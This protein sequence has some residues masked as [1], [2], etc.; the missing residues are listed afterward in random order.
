[1]RTRLTAILTIF[2]F[3]LYPIIVSADKN[4][5]VENALQKAMELFG[6]GK[7][8]EVISAC[9]AALKIDPSHVRTLAMRGGIQMM[10][11]NKE[12]ALK[13]WDNMPKSW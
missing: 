3:C 5:K 11:G 7:W 10:T 9:T 13:D 2:L 4:E 12:S 1:M 6:K 8:E